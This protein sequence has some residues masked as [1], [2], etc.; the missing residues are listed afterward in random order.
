MFVQLR[1]HDPYYSVKHFPFVGSAHKGIVYWLGMQSPT[2]TWSNPAIKG[3]DGTPERLIITRSSS[4]KGRASDAAALAFS[5]SCTR[6]NPVI[7]E[8]GN[9]TNWYVVEK[10]II[11]SCVSHH[12][13]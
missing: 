7:D 13:L 10:R 6:R 1:Q 9:H 12:H 11:L 2:G 8:N 3:E 5:N 4:A